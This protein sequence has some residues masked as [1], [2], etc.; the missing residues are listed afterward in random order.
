M[1]IPQDEIG[2]SYRLLQVFDDSVPTKG[3]LVHKGWQARSI[4]LPQ[5]QRIEA[6]SERRV[7]ALAEVDI[8]S[9]ELF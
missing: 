3:V 9:K 5:S 1:T 7:L 8:K 2:R 6:E 4:R